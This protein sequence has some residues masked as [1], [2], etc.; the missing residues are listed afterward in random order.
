[1]DDKSCDIQYALCFPVSSF[2]VCTNIMIHVI[3]ATVSSLSHT[4]S[5]SGSK[6]CVAVKM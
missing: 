2:I 3:A 6:A 1:M 5:F 4:P